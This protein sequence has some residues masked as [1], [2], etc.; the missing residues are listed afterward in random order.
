MKVL[1]VHDIGA[2][3]GG[4]EYSLLKIRQEL[5]RRG[6]E[7]KTV[8]GDRPRPEPG[9]SDF[10]FSSKDASAAGKLFHYLHNS[11]AKK[12]VATAIEDFHPDVIH[13]CT[14]TMLSPAGMKAMRA[15]PVVMDLRD[16]GLMYPFMH[17]YLPRE[18]F[19]GYGDEACCPQHAGY[20]RYY[21]EI[22]RIYL[23][24]RRFG[25]IS[26]FIV[27]SNFM[28]QLADSMGMKPAVCLE[29]P[30]EPI[31]DDLPGEPRHKNGILYAG[32]LEPE[33]GIMELLDGFELILRAHPEAELLIAG[34]GSLSAGIAARMR[35]GPLG[36]SVKLLGQLS[37]PELHQW[38]GRARLLVVPS[39]WPEPFGR[40]G[41]EAMAFGVPVVGSGRGGMSDWLED[42][43]NG[44][45]ADPRDAKKMAGAIMIL[46]EDE[47][48]H[49]EMS[50]RARASAGRFRLDS[51]IDKLER[52]YEE[53]IAGSR[54]FRS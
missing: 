35:N 15:T 10:T 3:V 31:P 54:R 23:H 29:N 34:E 13:A 20:R 24:R 40:V 14:V 33:K 1:I 12:T 51:Y 52:L 50:L 42:G 9:F 18:D 19:C 28:K 22:L 49:R 25:Q 11:S 41:P 44:L 4:A 43:R 5:T 38:Y 17:K 27:N 7:V 2:L 47:T 8:T 48:L 39:L 32:R 46:L 45:I 36:K 26:A 6:H 53:A 37:K 30:I 21:F 16:F